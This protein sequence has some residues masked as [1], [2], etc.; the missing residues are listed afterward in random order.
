MQKCMGRAGC[1]LLKQMFQLSTHYTYIFWVHGVQCLLVH[2]ELEEQ[3]LL[4]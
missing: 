3:E 4:N 2:G 1:V